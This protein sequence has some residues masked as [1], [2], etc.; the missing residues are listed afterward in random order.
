[1][2]ECSGTTFDKP[3][4]RIFASDDN[5]EA[6]DKQFGQEGRWMHTKPFVLGDSDAFDI[7]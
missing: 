4:G 3:S 7:I 5:W 1:M 2:L 6:F